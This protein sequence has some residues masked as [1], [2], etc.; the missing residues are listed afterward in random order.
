NTQI[1]AKGDFTNEGLINGVSVDDRA[2]TVIKVGGRLTNTG[3][4]R[5]YGDDIAL[6]ADSIENSDKD[7]GGSEILSAVVAARGNL[8]LAAREI[9][10]NTAYY[11]SD[12]QVGATL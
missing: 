6:Q 11:L 9:E 5:I 12:N 8:D 2:N 7:Y 1:T 10:N 4:G 3:K